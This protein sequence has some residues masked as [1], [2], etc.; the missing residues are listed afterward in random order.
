MDFAALDQ[1][2]GLMALGLTGVWMGTLTF[3]PSIAANPRVAIT[4]NLLSAY[5]FVLYCCED[6]DLSSNKRFVVSQFIPGISYKRVGVTFLGVMAAFYL[7]LTWSMAG[8][9]ARSAVQPSAA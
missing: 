1:R 2:T 3:R 5:L 4:L 9:C 6:P 7:Y 8:S